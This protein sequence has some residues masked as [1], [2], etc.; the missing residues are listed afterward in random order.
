MSDQTPAQELITEEKARILTDIYLHERYFDFGRITF[1][2]IEKDMLDD[3]PIYRLYGKVR[4]KSRSMLDRL[5]IDKDAYT[6][7]LMAEINAVSG[8]VINYEFK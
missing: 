1:T 2:N 3:K 8:R 6:Y 7:K 5:I 4:I